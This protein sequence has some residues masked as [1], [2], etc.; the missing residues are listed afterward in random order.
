M[1]ISWSTPTLAPGLDD[2]GARVRIAPDHHAVP[3]ERVVRVLGEAGAV[4]VGPEADAVQ[5]RVV[6]AEIP[7]SGGA[8]DGAAAP[9]VRVAVGGHERG[10]LEVGRGPEEARRIGLRLCRPV[11]CHRRA[12]LLGR[13]GGEP[14]H[15]QPRAR[16]ARESRLAGGRHPERAGAAAGRASARA[17]APGCRSGGPCAREGVVDEQARRSPGGPRPR[18]RATG[19]SGRRTPRCG[20]RRR[21]G[22][23]RGRAARSTGCRAWP[24]A[25]R[26]GPD[27]CREARPRRVPG[28]SGWSGPRAPPGTPRAPS[29]GRSPRRSG[30]RSPSSS[31]SRRPRRAPPRRGCPSGSDG[32]RS[33]RRGHGFGACICA[34]RPNFTGDACRVVASSRARSLVTQER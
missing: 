31:R 33:R 2:A 18:P 6:V 20:T 27:G 19:R 22:P 12:Q 7:P 34:I 15:A 11:R 26:P 24:R 23:C 17:S 8:R 9:V 30:A 28:G 16:R 14:E 32:R 4:E 13:D 21:P 5:R 25:R 3:D 29:C 10:D 1:R